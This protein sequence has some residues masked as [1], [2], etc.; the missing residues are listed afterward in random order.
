MENTRVLIATDEQTLKNVLNE[1][2]EKKTGTKFTPDFE[3]D[4][5]SKSQTCHMIGCTP[6][7][8]D[9]LTKEG[10]FKRYSLGSRVYYL[11]SEVVEALRK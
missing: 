8:L 6:P 7:T 4:K 3:E 9:K 5:I 1:M 2:F 10:R 11:K